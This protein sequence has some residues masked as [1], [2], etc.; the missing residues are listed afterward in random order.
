MP[1][2]EKSVTVNTSIE[3]LFN[4]MI[5]PANVMEI[6]PPEMKM[7]LIEV[8]EVLDANSIMKVDLLGFGIPQRVIYEI[9][10]FSTPTSFT[11]TQKEGPVQ[12]WIQ[13]HQFELINPETTI[14][15]ERIDFEPPGGML[16]FMITADRIKKSLDEGIGHRQ[17]KLQQLFETGN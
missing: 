2:F 16:G 1:V 10:E 14:L 12:K 4:F 13:Y 5:R 6:N 11:M 8:P 3:N 9:T 15:T 17:S 7:N